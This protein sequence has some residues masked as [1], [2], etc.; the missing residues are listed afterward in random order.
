LDGKWQIN[1]AGGSMGNN[2][3]YSANLGV[4]AYFL[5]NK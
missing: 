4:G 1:K 3:D 5:N 2:M